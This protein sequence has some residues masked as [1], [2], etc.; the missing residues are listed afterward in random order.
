MEWLAYLNISHEWEYKQSWDHGSLSKERK[1][2]E[3]SFLEREGEKIKI[4]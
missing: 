3:I 1:E 4:T 2:N